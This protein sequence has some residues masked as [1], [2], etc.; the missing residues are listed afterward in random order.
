MARNRG[1]AVSTAGLFYFISCINI[2][3]HLD[4]I[5]AKNEDTHPQTI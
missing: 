3:L 5:A 2:L 4:S 1:P